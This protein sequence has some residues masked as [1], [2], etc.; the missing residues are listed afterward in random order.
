ML[1]RLIVLE[2]FYRVGNICV[3]DYKKLFNVYRIVWWIII[4]IAISIDKLMVCFIFLFV[5][6][7]VYLFYLFRKSLIIRIC[8]LFFVF[9]EYYFGEVDELRAIY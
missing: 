3:S 7:F 9:I 6:L 5:Y 2:Q 8:L 4:S 1:L